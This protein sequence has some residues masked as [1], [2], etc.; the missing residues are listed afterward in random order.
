MCF[1]RFF[2]LLLVIVGALNWGL[3]GIFQYDVV[4]DIFGGNATGW[5]RFVYSII[6]IAGLYGLSFFFCKGFYNCSL[7][8]KGESGCSEEPKK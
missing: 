3:W 2:V 8:K 1:V 5:S 4:A 6:G 7:A